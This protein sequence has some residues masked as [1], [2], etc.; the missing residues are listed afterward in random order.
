MRFPVREE[1]TASAAPTV[2][3]ATETTL[4]AVIRSPE[5]ASASR[6][7]EVSNYTTRAYKDRSIYM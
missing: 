1:N 2:V 3:T 6:A 4:T 5:G 7:G